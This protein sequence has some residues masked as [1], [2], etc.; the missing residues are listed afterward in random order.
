MISRFGS[1]RDP[2]GGQAGGVE[3]LQARRLRDRVPRRAEQVRGVVQVDEKDARQRVH[4]LEDQHPPRVEH[5]QRRDLDVARAIL[6]RWVARGVLEPV[7]VLADCRARVDVER[8]DPDVER[9]V[10]GIR[11]RVEQRALHGGVERAVDQGRA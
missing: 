2:R 3:L 6:R 4:A 11:V 5:R 1:T 8:E 9:G 10:A 7:G